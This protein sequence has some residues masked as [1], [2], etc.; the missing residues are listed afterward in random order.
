MRETE[1]KIHGK[2]WREAK[3]W[4]DTLTRKGKAIEICLFNDISPDHALFMSDVEVSDMMI[5]DYYKAKNY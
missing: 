1:P 5:E 3:A 4:W 2:Y